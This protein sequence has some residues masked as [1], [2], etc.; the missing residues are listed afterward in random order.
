[1]D[2][3]TGPSS[4]KTLPARLRTYQKERL[5][6]RLAVPLAAAVGYSAV[7]FPALMA[8]RNLPGPF[9]YLIAFII[10]L[11]FQLQG[12]IADDLRNVR[13]DEK[14]QPRRPIPRGLVSPLELKL[15]FLALIP[16]QALSG[17]VV[18][19]RI[20]GPLL[21]ALVFLLFLTLGIGPLKWN[22][23]NPLFYL[24]FHRLASPVTLFSISALEWL[25][26]QGTPP[27]ALFLLLALSF[28]SGFVL[29]IGRNF[30]LPGQD[31]SVPRSY[32]KYWGPRKAVVIWWLLINLSAS[33]ASLIQVVRGAPP[34]GLLVLLAG[35]LITGGFAYRVASTLNP[36]TAARLGILSGFWIVT[37][38]L[39]VV[40]G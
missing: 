7:T 11:C 15:L 19:I 16:V 2:T 22:A 8:H 13:F 36:K 33:F 31:P 21:V 34:G 3:S 9:L 1:M 12:R 20:F 28:L 39:T 14:N 10:T 32:A 18:D 25:P 5:P 6:I 17:M 29:E 23:E 37:L 35:V 40:I 27:P 38:F 26:R 30:D 24:F 4:F